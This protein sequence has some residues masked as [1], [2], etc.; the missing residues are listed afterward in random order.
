[1]VPLFFSRSDGAIERRRV[2]LAAWVPHLSAPMLGILDRWFRDRAP[3]AVVLVGA[4]LVAAIGVLNARITSDVTFSVFYLAPIALVAWYAP[5][6]AAVLLS[7]LAG[8]VWFVAGFHPNDAAS[9]GWIPYWNTAVR[10]G[11][12][13]TV[14]VLAAGLREALER[15]RVA[16]RIDPLTGLLRST[17]FLDIARTELQRARRYDRPFAIAYVDAD[18][19]KAVNDSAGHMEGDRVLAAVGATL[20]R[21][22]RSA[23][24][25]GRMGGDEF[26]LLLP[27]TQADGARLALENVRAALRSAMHAGGWPVTFSIG[28]VAYH[29]PPED[30]AEAVRRAD[31]AMY[32]VK[33]DHKD[34]V[35]VVQV[36]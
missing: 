1:V 20:R 10:V 4:G 30:I 15:E 13:L 11:V 16:A 34:A 3:T 32:S 28:A 33:R 31:Q 26:T 35:A 17:A 18:N 7:L 29:T 2:A 23:D 27:E 5:R 6:R 9:A 19:F 12:F 22:L 36:S 24:T 21:H 25:A 14:A 8:A